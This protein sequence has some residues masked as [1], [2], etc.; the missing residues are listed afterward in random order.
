[1]R[2]STIEAFEQVIIERDKDIGCAE[3][4]DRKLCVRYSCLMNLTSVFFT[5]ITTKNSAKRGEKGMLLF[6]PPGFLTL[7][8]HSDQLKKTESRQDKRLGHSFQG[9]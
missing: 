6:F 9:L 8:A 7:T 4:E 3:G 1:M 2:R 5:H